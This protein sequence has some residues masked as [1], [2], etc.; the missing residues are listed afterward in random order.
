MVGPGKWV[1]H[2]HRHFV[3]SCL[4]VGNQSASHPDNCDRHSL[5]LIR[6]SAK[7]SGLAVNLVS[8]QHATG[9]G[10]LVMAWPVERAVLSGS[11][12]VC[13]LL[14]NSLSP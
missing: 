13:D 6:Y 12:Y 4:A 14:D 7:Q 2:S 3:P 1:T 9:V 8:S 5:C 11:K 10:L